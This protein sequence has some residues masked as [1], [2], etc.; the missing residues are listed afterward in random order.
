MS[1]LSLNT[2]AS[3]LEPYVGTAQLPP[4]LYSQLSIYLELILK[5]NARV[6]LT[7]IRDPETIIQRH[8][9]ESLFAG[10]HLDQNCDSLLDFGSGAGF[11][12][13]PIQLLKP[14]LAITLAESRARKASFLRE[15]VRVLDLK[16]AVWADRVE[17]M[18]E[19]WH[20]DTVALRAV[21]DMHAAIAEASKRSARQ[22]LILGTR[23]AIYPGLR[24]FRMK[25]PDLLPNSSTGVIWIGRRAEV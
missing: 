6:N 8:F 15:V 5:W 1:A 7:A 14:D 3:L 25:E 10:L 24:E 2:I 20:F 22:I 4:H 11:P 19:E 9:G 21:D 12:G 18:P 13:I 23:D 16:T 17:K